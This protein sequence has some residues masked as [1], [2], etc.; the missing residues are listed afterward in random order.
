VKYL[1]EVR[2][3]LA[4]HPESEGIPAAEVLLRIDPD[5]AA[6]RQLLTRQITNKFAIYRL[7]ACET[8]A[9]MN[10]Q[11]P[12]VAPLLEQA[13]KDDNAQIRGVATNALG[14]KKGQ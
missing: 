9:R 3:F 8:L 11:T 2:I 13:V 14:G 5:D 12:W 4:R 7:L 6:S 1:P 10:E